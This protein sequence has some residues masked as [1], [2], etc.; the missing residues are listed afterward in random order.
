MGFEIGRRHAPP[1]FPRKTTSGQ[2]GPKFPVRPATIF[3][4]FDVVPEQI[5]QAT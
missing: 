2:L 5:V 1:P 3:L 4:V